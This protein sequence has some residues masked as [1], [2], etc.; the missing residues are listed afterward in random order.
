MG[1]WSQGNDPF[2]TSV[3]DG[4]ASLR[5]MVVEWISRLLNARHV[6][7]QPFARTKVK[8][9]RWPILPVPHAQIVVVKSLNRM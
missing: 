9:N 7:G 5:R 2:A 8:L 4:G 3:L 6:A 1:R